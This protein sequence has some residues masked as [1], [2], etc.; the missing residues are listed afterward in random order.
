[1]QL[2]AEAVAKGDLTAVM[3]LLRVLDRYD[4]YR[5]AARA[6][7]VSNA[8]IR[9]KLLDRLNRMAAALREEEARKNEAARLKEVEAANSLAEDRPSSNPSEFFPR[10]SG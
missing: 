3:P 8:N 10:N 7:Q 1:M 2:S 4:R 9:Q 6:S 5:P